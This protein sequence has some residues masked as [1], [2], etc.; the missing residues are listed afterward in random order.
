MQVYSCEHIMPISTGGTYDTGTFAALEWHLVDA[1]Q[2]Q[3]RF[4]F[5]PPTTVV[6]MLGAGLAAIVPL[7]PVQ[8]LRTPPEVPSAAAADM[9]DVA[10][11][12]DIEDVLR[13]YPQEQ[14]RDFC[15]KLVQGM[16]QFAGH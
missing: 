11:L 12:N 15:D 7:L 5:V 1:L 13:R 8:D 9:S 16:Q 14:R 6:D 10:F 2:L 4:A 3:R